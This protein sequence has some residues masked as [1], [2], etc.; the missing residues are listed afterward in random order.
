VN[1]RSRL[2]PGAY[3]PPV[4][5]EEVK[6]FLVVEHDDDDA[7]ID[8]I[9]QGVA[10]RAERVTGLALAHSSYV[11]DV[12]TGESSGI[13]RVDFPVA[14]VTAVSEVM[15]FDE[16][17]VETALTVGSNGYRWQ[18]DTLELTYSFGQYERARITFTAGFD[19][20]DEGLKVAL[21]DAIAWVYEHRGQPE[22]DTAFRERLF[23][24]LR[25]FA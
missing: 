14:P 20:L 16:D 3:V 23:P 2:T 18:G 11:Y 4:S 21:M 10:G 5:L 7:L 13:Y 24:F 1:A 19:T 6:A 12:W 22:A 8:S 9:I 17:A 15:H 25:V